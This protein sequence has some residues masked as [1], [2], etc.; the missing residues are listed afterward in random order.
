MK[1][2]FKREFRI[3]IVIAIKHDFISAMETTSFDFSQQN[4]LIKINFQH[5]Y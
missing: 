4:I 5:Q 3:E 1:V 2:Q